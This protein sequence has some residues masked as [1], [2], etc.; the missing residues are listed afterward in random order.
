MTPNGAALR[1]IREAR[2]LSLRRLADLIERTP[3]Y[4]SRIER[5]LQPA[6]AETLRRCADA[7]NVPLDAI[8]RETP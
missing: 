3:G 6:G 7:L 8:T 4:L 2:G 5:N 1:S